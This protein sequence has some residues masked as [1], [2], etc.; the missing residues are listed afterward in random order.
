MS[1]A[2]RCQL[3]AGGWGGGMSLGLIMLKEHKQRKAPKK[4]GINKRYFKNW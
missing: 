4:E 2:I 1:N 3:G